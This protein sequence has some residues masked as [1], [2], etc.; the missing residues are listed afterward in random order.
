MSDTLRCFTCQR[1]LPVDDFSTDRKPSCRKRGFRRY[2]CRECHGRW[3]AGRRFRNRKLIREAKDVPC[4]DG[5]MCGGKRYDFWIM[6][7]DHVRGEKLFDLSQASGRAIQTVKDEIAKC[8]IVCSNCHAD[9]TY[10]RREEALQR[11]E[12]VGCI[13]PRGTRISP[14]TQTS[15]LPDTLTLF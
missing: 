12:T 1:D 2:A 10:K 7:F 13:V 11:G 9:R 3:N 8:D 6:Q 5:T 14:K 4:M 15:S